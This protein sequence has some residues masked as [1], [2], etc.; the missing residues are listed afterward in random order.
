MTVSVDGPGRLLSLP[1]AIDC[2]GVCSASFA[3]GTPVTL[4]ATSA[5]EVT[6]V[7]WSGDC[8]GAV[9]CSFTVARDAAVS[10][11]FAPLPQ[12]K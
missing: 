6:F 4:L 1:P 2:P 7:A 11:R 12:K 3:A 5:D 10:A 9:G 8:S